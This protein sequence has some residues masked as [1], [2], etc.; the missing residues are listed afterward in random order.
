MKILQ[1][2]YSLDNGCTEKFVV[3]LSNGQS[4]KN[5]VVLCSVKK[6]RGLDVST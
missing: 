4:K 6:D 5:E 1:V 3:E 2:I